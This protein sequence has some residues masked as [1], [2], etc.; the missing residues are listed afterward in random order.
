MLSVN[1]KSFISSFTIY[2]YFVPFSYLMALAKTFS[3][4]LKRNG[5][6]KHPCLVPDFSGKSMFLT[7]KCDISSKLFVYILY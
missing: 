5:E 2:I 4:M 3:M 6:R 7:I 1:K